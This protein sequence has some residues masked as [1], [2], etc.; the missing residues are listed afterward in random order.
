MLEF[1]V[2]LEILIFSP[3]ETGKKSKRNG[4]YNIL[5]TIVRIN[6]SFF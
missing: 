6:T 2:D 3:I 5:F 4:A 1:Q